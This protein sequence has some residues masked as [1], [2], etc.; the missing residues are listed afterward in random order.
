MGWNS[1]KNLTSGDVVSFRL[2]G[3]SNDLRQKSYHG[4]FPT[5]TDLTGKVVRCER[6]DYSGGY[7][8]CV[9]ISHDA[10]GNKLSSLQLTQKH[11]W[12]LNLCVWLVLTMF[13]QC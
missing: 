9:E 4:R 5:N 13:L 1:E 11:N 7:Q 12:F 10:Q 6:V 8:V 2:T 3:D